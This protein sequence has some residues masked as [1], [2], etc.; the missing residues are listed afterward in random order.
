LLVGA[1]GVHSAARRIIDPAAPGPR[2]TGLGNVGGFARDVPI[3][4]SPGDYNMIWG[5]NC[6]FGYTVSPD[7]AIWWFA[8]PPSRTEIPREELRRLTT[9]QLRDRLAGLL[10]VDKTP[11][12]QIVQATT[13]EFRLTNQYDL[14]AVPVW[15]DQA[16]V[17][18]GDAAHAVSPAS[19]QGCSLAFEDAATLALC[20]RDAATVPQALRVYEQRRRD[21]V[22][23]IVS[24]GSGMNQTKRQGLTGR[25]LRDL[26]LPIILK[27]A[28]RPEEMTKMSWMFGHHIEWKQPV[29]A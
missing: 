18:I 29:T 11:G 26:V 28:S 17:I 2:Y 14:P 7:G 23:Q 4:A 10:A 3:A 5:K 19:G 1:D 6:F 15:H 13:E 20:L 9:A 12:A 22:E 25:M 27:K 8:N 16:M 21:R 24:W